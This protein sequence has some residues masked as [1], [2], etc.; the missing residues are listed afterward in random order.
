MRIWPGQPYPLGATWD[1]SGVN[2]ALFSEVAER[3]ELCLF[4]DS[5]APVECARYRLPEK[6]YRVFHGYFPDIKPGTVYGFRVHGPYDPSAGHRCNPHKLVFDPYARAVGRTLQWDD[7]LFGYT[8]GAGGGDLSYDTRDSAAFAPLAQVVDSAFTWGD[9]CPPRT[10]WEQTIIYEIHIKGFTRRM[11]GVPERL[12]GTYAGLASEV[13]IR[14]LRQLGITAVELLPVHFHVDE[15]FLVEQGRDN[16]W[17]YNTLGFFALDPRYASVHDAELAMHEFKS[18]VRTLHAAGIEVILDVVYNHTAE[19]NQWGPT[20]SLRGIDNRSYYQLAQDNLR[21]YLDY[22]GCGNTPRLQHP[23]VLQLIMDSLRYWVTEMHVDGFRFD[24]AATLARQTGNIDLMNG[25]LNVIHQ[26]PILSQVKL[27]AE[28]WDVGE[29]GYQVGQFPVIWTEWNGR[30]RDCVRRFWKGDGSTVGELAT[31]M[32][33]SADLYEDDGRRPSAS[34]NFITCHDGFTLRDL[35]LYHQKHNEANGEDNRDGSNVND[36]WNCGVEGPSTDPA[37]EA[38]RRRQMRNLLATLLVS[39]GVPMLRGG[40]ELSHTSRGN[41]NCYCQ[42]NELSWLDWN[43]GEGDREFLEFVRRLIE[44]R[45]TQPALCRRNFFQGS[46]LGGL[47]DVYWLDP[48]GT[49]MSVDAWNSNQLRT[50]GILLL[51]DCRQTGQ[52]GES[53]VGDHLLILLNAHDHGIDFQMPPSIHEVPGLERLFDTYDGNIQ[54]QEF[55][56]HQPYH[57]RPRSMALFR[58]QLAGAIPWNRLGTDAETSVRVT[59]ESQSGKP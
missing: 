49:Q 31:R 50:L 26:D 27:I 36:S 2:F 37:T 6:T 24:L 56:P 48:S 11:P 44:I 1:G 7:S 34:V 28:P 13:S 57:L 52:T 17:G 45:R 8:P 10:P 43:L 29:N 42:D 25:F 14:H 12:R 53:I 22:T 5:A 47:R 16:Y 46:I 35:V 9:D 39:Q 15:R 58:K 20:L 19:G 3:V 32:S 33:G 59:A 38:L 4:D 51:G 55:D 30:Y 40:D 18:M 41:N 21:Y 23:H 54:R